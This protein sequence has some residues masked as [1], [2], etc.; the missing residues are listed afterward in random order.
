MD[1]RVKV[2]T[3]NVG[4]TDPSSE[5]QL[6]RLIGDTLTLD[7]I[8]IGLQEIN[9]GVVTTALSFVEYDE[10]ARSLMLVLSKLGFF[11]VESQRMQG[12]SLSVFMK[13]QHVPYLRSIKIGLERTGLEGNWG[14]KGGVAVS[15]RLYTTS[16]CI[17]NTHLP[18]HMQYEKERVRDFTQILHGITFNNTTS[19]LNHDIVLWCG[20]TNFRL[21][22]IPR[23]DVIKLT[24][25]NSYEKL[26]QHDQLLNQMRKEAIFSG[27]IEAPIT[28][29]PTYKF[30]P[31]TDIYD[32]S[33]KQRK[34]AWTDRILY[35]I[36]PDLQHI[37]KAGS[38]GLIT[39][40]KDNSSSTVPI[41]QQL[42]GCYKCNM[43]FYQSDHKPV[44]NQYVIKVDNK[45]SPLVEINVTTDWCT[46][47]D[48]GMFEMKFNQGFKP[49]KDD[50]IG[51]YQTPIT[52]HRTYVQWMW[53]PQQQQNSVPSSETVVHG[54]FPSNGVVHGS[55]VLAYYCSKL[56]CVLTI[57][58]PFHIVTNESSSSSSDSSSSSSEG[59]EENTKTK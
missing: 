12:M 6:E 8:A 55:Y 33:E 27:F 26:L 24:K 13:K 34:P 28:F 46:A 30:D 44:E 11:M 15:M 5:N 43:S 2:L 31:G 32:T 29:P 52:D 19:I 14:N 36:H 35:R 9:T 38:T 1:L 40:N 22:D 59:E 56:T 54:S 58:K 23:D 57:S 49:E 47:D 48:K 3:W 42:E 10:W 50:W 41:I 25:T 39:T 53:S 21:S 17:L 16:L 7:I 4:N 37:K 18:A 45:H 20:D 51:L